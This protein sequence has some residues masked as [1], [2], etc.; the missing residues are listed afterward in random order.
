[1]H[2]SDSY[3]SVEEF[4]CTS[5]TESYLSVLGK[6]NALPEFSVVSVLIKVFH[7]F[8]KKLSLVKRSEC[9]TL[10]V[11]NAFLVSPFLSFLIVEGLIY[12]VVSQIK[13]ILDIILIRTVENG[14]CDIES[15][16]LCSKRKMDLKHLSDVHSGRNAERVK[17]DIKGSAVRKIRHIFNRKYS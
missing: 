9:I 11:L 3:R 2:V 15:E 12:I 5:V 16:S 13:G 6:R 4:T 1:M 8:R 14:G 10:L 17:H 7:N